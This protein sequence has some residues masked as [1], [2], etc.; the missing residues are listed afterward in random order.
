MVE[1][2]TPDATTAVLSLVVDA[3]PDDVFAMFTEPRRLAGWFW[4]PSFAAIYEASPRAGGRFS[5]RTTGLQAGHN[6]AVHGIYGEVRRPRTLTFIWAWDGES[7]PASR[8]QVRLEPA[9]D[10][11]TELVLTHSDNPTEEQRDDHLKGWHESLSRLADQLVV[12]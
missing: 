9:A 11:G 8:V 5:F 2:S 4:P 12:G 10:G 7:V 1:S 3:D 6:I